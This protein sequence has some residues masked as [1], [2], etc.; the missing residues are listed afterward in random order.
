VLRMERACGNP[1][2]G[3][4][5][6]YPDVRD[7]S[8]RHEEIEPLLK[9]AT[10]SARPVS[11]QTA[12]D[13]RKW[14]S[15]VEDQGALGAC[16]ANAGAGV[17]EYFQ[18][19]SFGKY[20]DGSRL[21][22]YKMSRKLAH[23][24]GDSGAFIRS[25][26]GALALFGLSPEEYWP[27]DADGF[28]EEPPAFCYAFAQGYRAVK[29]YRLDEP[30]VEGEELVQAIKSNLSA[31]IPAVFGFTVYDSISSS[32]ATGR[33]PFPRAGE[34]VVGGHAVAAVGFNDG[35]AITSQRDGGRET[36]GAF[37]IR[38]S[39]GESW[40]EHGYGWLP[41]EYVLSGLARDWWSLLSADWIDTQPFAND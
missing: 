2:M 3:W 5:P 4:L 22:L 37:L 9:Q 40:G 16:T 17:V 15:P 39:W 33:I 26:M 21:F 24:S 35:I 28:D 10:A 25:T 41:Y 6:D 27:Y 18:L 13:L 38:N 12:V 11:G 30:G 20:I 1:A 32:S 29:Y 34:R 23:L 31:E 36:V 14:C 8:S 19:K 7:Y